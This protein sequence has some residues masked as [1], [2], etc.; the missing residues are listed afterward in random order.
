MITDDHL[1]HLKHVQDSQVI[2]S[3]GGTEFMASK[4]TMKSDRN[5]LLARIFDPDSP[6]TT[7]GGKYFFDRDSHHFRLILNYF[8]N[9]YSLDYRTLP[10][11]QLY[12]Y[13]MLSESEFFKLDGFSAL[14]RYKIPLL[15]SCGL[16]HQE[17]KLS[18]YTEPYSCWCDGDLHV[19]KKK[20]M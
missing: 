14:I 8:R 12:L 6:F 17:V 11:D 9:G 20:R 16:E 13:E 1:L 7:R 2:T 10:C 15:Y 4:A 5:S 18:F 19:P 3:I